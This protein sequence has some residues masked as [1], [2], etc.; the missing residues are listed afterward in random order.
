MKYFKLVLYSYDGAGW[1]I[2]CNFGVSRISGQPTNDLQAASSET[3][4]SSWNPFAQDCFPADS[5]GAA[6]AAVTAAGATAAS[7]AAAGDTNVD[8]DPFANAPF[9]TSSSN[10]PPPPPAKKWKAC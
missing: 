7:A 8:D 9:G 4:I 3:A 10:N 5:S 2:N 6:P 1:L